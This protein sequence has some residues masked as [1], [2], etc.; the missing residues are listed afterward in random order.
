LSI[1]ITNQILHKNVTTTIKMSRKVFCSTRVHDCACLAG[2]ES[3][4][5]L[6]TLDETCDQ[7]LHLLC[8]L[9]ELSIVSAAEGFCRHTVME[10]QLNLC[11]R[12]EK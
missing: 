8:T 6:N 7:V 5:P 4:L 11:F 3:L 9:L 2:L 1:L 12:N 10:L